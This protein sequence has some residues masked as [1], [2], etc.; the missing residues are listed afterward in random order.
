MKIYTRTGDDGSTGL[1]GGGRV[2]KNHPR[3]RAYGTVDEVNATLGLTVSLLPE[4]D[5]TAWI[6]SLLL[7]IQNELFILGADLATPI[8]SKAAVPRI[9]TENVERLEKAIDD[10]DEALPDLVNFILPGG[11]RA[12]AALHL[13][14]TTC[15]RAEREVVD[16]SE[17][18]ELNPLVMRYLNR[19]SDLLFVAART[20]NHE[21]G[22]ADVT[23]KG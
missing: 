20:V 14:R 22:I 9:G 2:E 7:S 5:A 1:F 4:E 21:L 19:L 10:T 16:A 13:A 8:G 18:D 15:R 17:A 12:A 23:W 3:I 6:R 11:H